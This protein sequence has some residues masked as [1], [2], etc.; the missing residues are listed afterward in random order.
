[1]RWLR[2]F[3]REDPT[4][5]GVVLE[6]NGMNYSW[7]ARISTYTGLPT[8]VGWPFHELQ[9]RAAMDEQVI[10]DAW[11]D[12]DRI[13]ATTDNAEALEMLKRRK[14]R[15]VFVGQLENGTI[16]NSNVGNPKQYSPEALAKFGSFMK[17][18]YADP[19]NNI[20]IYAFY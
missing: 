3:T 7:Y 15:Y 13:Y 14:V 11:L 12:M 20:F 2:D 10:W 18:I 5:R 17:T 4:R 9:W 6:A 16:I 8:V 19:E 1:M